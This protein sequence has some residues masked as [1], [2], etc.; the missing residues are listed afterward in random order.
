MVVLIASVA[1]LLG[2]AGAATPD[3]E[4]VTPAR[5]SGT[6]VG[7][8]CESAS[9]SKI[10]RQRRFLFTER[11]WKIVVQVY[12]DKSCSPDALLFTADFGGDY[13]LGGASAAVP[14]A[15]EARFSF[16]H[17]LVTPTEGGMDF[18]QPR[19]PQYGWQPNATRDIGR[20]GCGDLF[21]SVPSCP[22]EYDL[23]AIDGGMLR[24]GDRGHPLCTPATRPTK[25]Q[26]LGF[27][28][29]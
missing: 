17:K 4:S 1:A 5:L 23:V 8:Q 20:E 27:A 29:Q 25:L 11:A 26:P 24:L 14:G 21:V 18:L 22:A 15:R 3:A 6:W 13:Q 28:K 7:I 10:S 12:G 19:C 2:P 9:Y 16:D